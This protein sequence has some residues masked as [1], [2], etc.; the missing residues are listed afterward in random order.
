M[1][2]RDQRRHGTALRV[3]RLSLSRRGIRLV[4]VTGHQAARLP[5]IHTAI[6]SDRSQKA[7]DFMLLDCQRPAE[8]AV[9]FPVREMLCLRL[10]RSVAS[11]RQAFREC[12]ES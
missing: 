6:S 4:E 8:H 10:N 2:S 9:L 3:P 5:H 12:S 7:V 1:A 11:G